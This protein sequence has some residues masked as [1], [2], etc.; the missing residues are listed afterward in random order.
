[1]SPAEFRAR[2]TAYMAWLDRTTAPALHSRA[3]LRLEEKVAAM[4]DEEFQAL[5][6][7][8]SDPDGL[9]QAAEQVM[10]GAPAP[11]GLRPV[12]GPAASA[13]QAPQAA[14]P[15]FA[16][17]YPSGSSYDV[18]VATLP[19]LGLLSDSEGDGSLA[20]ERGS[21]NGESELQITKAAF[22][23]AAIVA[24][25]ACDIVVVILGEGT[26][27]PACVIKG[28]LHETAQANAIVIS[29][30][31]VQDG[32]VDS[33]E[34]EATYENSKIIAA[35]AD[36][37]SVQL[38]THDTEIKAALQAHH[39]AITNQLT[40]N[41][42]QS[43]KIE[44]EKALADTNDNKRISY[45]YLPQANGGLLE[46]VRQTVYEAI[47]NNQAAGVSTGRAVELFN[48]ADASYAARQ[49]KAAYD[50]YAKAYKEAT[51]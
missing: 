7:S 36:A 18:W 44:I 19:G 49:Y 25:T 38:T 50:Q 30:T 39:V 20:N 31:S 15:L 21:S 33:A 35:Q 51:K 5:Y 11:A 13:L 26:N 8:F 29:Q 48:Q 37:L 16:P 34:I 12:Q 32:F 17:A 6:S 10:A 22:D 24:D 43:V 1:M 27:A 3:G 42:N 41:Q 40:A 14:T 28:V 47:A 45:F 23:V 2:Y 9:I 46:V 4:S